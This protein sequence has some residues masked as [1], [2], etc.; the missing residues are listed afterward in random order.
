MKKLYIASGLVALLAAATSC[1]KYDI[2]PE[3]YGEV[4]M[5]KNAGERSLTIYATDE[6]SPCYISVMKSG[7]TP[8]NPAQATLKILNE[9]EFG[10]YKEL[11]YG[12]RDFEGLQMLK[13]EF[14]HLE[15]ANG[16]VMASGQMT[17]DFVDEND[18]Y[19]GSNVVF[20]SQKV[21][22]WHNR[23]TEAAAWTSRKDPANYTEAEKIAAAEKE[24][25][26]DTL[27]NFTF[28]VPVGL[29]STTDSINADNRF[30]MIMPKVTNPVLEVSI[31]N[32]GY[33]LTD[34]SRADMQDASYRQGMFEP[35]VTLSVPCPNPYGFKAKFVTDA[36]FVST[37]NMCHNDIVLTA[38]SYKDPATGTQLYE[39]N[40]GIGLI[41][42]PKGKTEVRLPISIYRKYMDA[43]DLESNYVIGMQL[44]PW[45]TGKNKGIDMEWGDNVPEK[46]KKSLK[47]PTSELEWK[48]NNDNGTEK[49][50]YYTIYV[51]YRVVETPLTI[52]DDNFV[53][54]NDPEPSE[55]SFGGLFDDD[56]STF[57]HSAWKDPQPRSTPYGSYI[58]MIMPTKD[59]VKRIAIQITS[60]VHSDPH[61]PKV[62]S[63]YYSNIDNDDERN[64][65]W[66]VLKENYEIAGV[67]AKGSGKSY[68]IGGIKKDSDWLESPEPFRYL[69]FCVIK[70]AQNEDITVTGTSVAGYWNL[71]EMKIYGK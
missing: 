50:N 20:H 19:F 8:E 42:F 61:T 14:F 2:Y 30:L 59:P 29:F 6:A 23:L 44:Q 41:E 64:A 56:L 28:V 13:P 34:I 27:N 26:L 40:D 49:L 43:D 53:F 22:D 38:L 21:S 10:D 69:R 7:H 35:Q 57:Y 24:L 52:T 16:N 3:Q 47:L 63:L 54:A 9:R 1:D 39:M 12:R 17:H 25:A 4:M 62:I 5:I 71:A 68:W 60:R 31:D 18:R 55:G 11:Y 70:N 58:D 66:K 67:D 32:G 15:D 36:G 37:Y 48:H 51:G 33:Q 45:G 46:V 65:S